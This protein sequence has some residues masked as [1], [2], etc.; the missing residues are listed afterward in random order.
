VA[1]NIGELVQKNLEAELKLIEHQMDPHVI[2]NNFNNLYSIS[3]NRPE[4]LSCTV[5]SLKWILHYLF[6]ESKMQKVPLE[7]EIH[8]IEHYIGLEKLRYGEDRLEISYNMEGDAE[9]LEIAPLL[10][11]HFV[12]NCFVHGAGEDPERSWIDIQ[13]SVNGPNLRFYAANSIM[14]GR[15][16]LPEKEGEKASNNIIRRLELLY[17]NH[18]RLTIKEGPSKY[19]VELNMRLQA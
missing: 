12:E 9:S 2:F 10:L 11:Y 7:R 6:S 16:R 8:M 5:K 14:E 1:A 15:H 18:H 4:I 19:A 3:I 17:P 13:L